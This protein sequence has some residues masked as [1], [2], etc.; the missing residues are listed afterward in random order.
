M[1][2]W[3]VHISDGL[4]AF[5]FWAGGFVLAGLLLVWGS[6]KTP[7]EEISRIALATAAFFIASTIHVKV[8]GSSVH[9]L[10]N[11]LA[12]V[13]LGRRAVLA[14]AGGLGLQAFLL[15]HGGFYAL[16]VNTC[17]MTLPAYLAWGLFHGVRRFL[18]PG[19][20]LACSA[21]VFLC[22]IL[23]VLSSIFSGAM[24][25]RLLAN[26]N[27]WQDQL[28]AAWDFTLL[29]LSIGAALLLS[30]LATWAERRIHPTPT[31]ALGFFV[32]AV[33]VLCTSF[34]NCLVLLTGG[35]ELWPVAP[36]ALVVLHLPVAVIEGMVMGVTVGFLGKVK[37]ELLGIV[38]AKP[39]EKEPVLPEPEL[40]AST[41]EQDSP[42]EGVYKSLR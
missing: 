41:R 13:L 29:P 16:G 3:A 23:L 1:P 27:H 11:G 22:S 21:L 35:E 20:G 6:W 19:R 25:S 14:V 24:V 32:G 10:L 26:G 42:R 5:P 30:F 18:G 34:L 28:Q 9:L 36:W 39:E 33:T 8:P 2:L 38:L 40:L 12:G 31:F 7:E 37:P 17:V 4:L 15:G